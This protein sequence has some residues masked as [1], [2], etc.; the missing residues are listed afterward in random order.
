MEAE[1]Y[2][3]E[4]LRRI[5]DELDRTED[6]VPITPKT[7]LFQIDLEFGIT[8][9]GHPWSCGPGWRF[10]HNKSE[11]VFSSRETAIAA[12]EKRKK[13]KTDGGI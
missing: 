2:T 4:E 12:R 11:P 13:E 3:E 7:E 9:N 10:Q 8:N 1:L 6:G 5:V